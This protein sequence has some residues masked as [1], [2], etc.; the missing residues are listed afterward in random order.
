MKPQ[1][2][3]Q[4]ESLCRAS[5]NTL[6]LASQLGTVIIV[7]N[8]SPGWV[9]QSCKMFM[10][11]L[12]PELR[13]MKCVAKP[14]NAPVT[15]KIGA[16]KRECKHYTNLISVGDGD[17]ERM[18]SLKLQAP[19]DRL[20]R[21]KEEESFNRRVKS[22]KLAEA[23]TC[24]QLIVEHEMLQNRLMDVAVFNGHLDLRARFMA[25]RT[26]GSTMAV[27]ILGHFTMFGR[28]PPYGLRGSGHLPTLG[29]GDEEWSPH[30]A[31]A[32]SPTIAPRQ[33]HQQQQQRPLGDTPP[34][35]RPRSSTAQRR[36][37]APP[38]L[39]DNG[40]FSAGDE[41]PATPTNA[42]WP[43]TAGQQSEQ[44]PE[45]IGAPQSRP[46]SSPGARR[47]LESTPGLDRCRGS[48]AGGDDQ[49]IPSK[50]PPA[51]VDDSW[52]LVRRSVPAA[53]RPGTSGGVVGTGRGT[54]G[55]GLG[56]TSLLSRGGF[57]D[58]A[59]GAAVVSGVAQPGSMVPAGGG[60]V[61][62]Q[63]VR[64]GLGVYKMDSSTAASNRL[65]MGQPT[66]QARSFST[67]TLAPDGG[68][69]KYHTSLLTGRRL[70]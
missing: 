37:I 13:G 40:S 4:V 57:G 17:P 61:A 60:A 54:A 51:G 64:A 66:K 24:S 42:T 36:T 43:Q 28:A 12:M 65:R 58:P 11:L 52:L 34:G 67:G 31:S 27:C 6:R 48:A 45:W 7:T 39:T 68:A 29:S 46:P 44:A 70:A 9:D 3:D 30:K 15:F 56:G 41:A 33:S 47:R 18:A 2:R 55:V 50:Q 38:E 5:A 1:L 22:L 10:P 32:T 25:A 59:I 62:A 16:F 26:G 19:T 23:P 63:M 20:S 21:G 14:M 35:A 8:S 49:W 69:R 53:K